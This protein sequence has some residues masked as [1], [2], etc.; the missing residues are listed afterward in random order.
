M[1]K[2]DTKK[3][4]ASHIFDNGLESRTH[5]KFLKLNSEKTNSPLKR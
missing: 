1:K 3:I 4:F 2:Q 5:K